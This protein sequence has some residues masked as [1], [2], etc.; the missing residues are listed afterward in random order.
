MM[1]APLASST[2]PAQEHQL[3]GITEFFPFLLFSYVHRYHS[4]SQQ[5]ADFASCSMLIPH[6]MMS[7]TALLV[8]SVQSFHCTDILLFLFFVPFP[9]LVP[10]LLH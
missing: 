6:F 1:Q 3:T 9:P 8:F 4:S 10:L 2:F 5:A 7:R